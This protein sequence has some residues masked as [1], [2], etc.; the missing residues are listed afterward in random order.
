MSLTTELTTIFQDLSGKTAS[1][2]A[3]EI[4]TAIETNL[5]GSKVVVYTR[6]M[7]AESGDA[8]YTGAG[9][10]PKSMIV[11]SGFLASFCISFAEGTS[12]FP[13]VLYKTNLASVYI[14]TSYNIVV[15]GI[16]DEGN[17]KKQTAVIK[18]MD[19]DGCTLT[20]TKTGSPSA[21]TLNFFIKYFF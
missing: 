6:D 9:R 21:G 10:T 8:E 11:L 20:W 3:G 5:D 4:A 1:I 17:T 2:K 15:Y 13:M 16:E 14:N 19:S 18:S 7:T 12:G